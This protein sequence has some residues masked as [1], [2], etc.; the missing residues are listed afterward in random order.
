V[1]EHVFQASGGL[2]RQFGVEP[3]PSGADV[4]APPPGLHPLYA[5]LGYADAYNRFP[6]GHEGRYLVLHVLAVPVVRGLLAPFP[7]R[8]GAHVHVEEFSACSEAWRCLVFFYYESVSLP[9]EIVSLPTDQF[10]LRLAC[11][12]LKKAPLLTDPVQTGHE[13]QP[14]GLIIHVPGGGN[15]NVAIGRANAQVEVLY[16]R[17]LAQKS[18]LWFKADF[19]CKATQ[20]QERAQQV[21]PSGR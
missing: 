20:G 3:D 16:V 12:P 8:A 21:E 18:G 11:A 6:F 2:L 5:P 13:G 15:P 17:L 9:S 19:R 7:A 14:N 10:P 4:A 1:D